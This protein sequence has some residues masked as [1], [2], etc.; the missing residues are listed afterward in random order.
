MFL[1]QDKKEAA[2]Q[3]HNSKIS[4]KEVTNVARERV[5]GI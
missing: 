4:T 5:S 3:K 1:I 2:A